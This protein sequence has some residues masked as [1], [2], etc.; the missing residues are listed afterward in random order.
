LIASVE[1]TE[2]LAPRTN[3]VSAKV[4]LP[5]TS[6]ASP[7]PQSVVLRCTLGAGA[8]D[9]YVRNYAAVSKEPA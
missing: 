9:R 8:L 1:K 3:V 5:S 4:A 7:K 6:R 2:R